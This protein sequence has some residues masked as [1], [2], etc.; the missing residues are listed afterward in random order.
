MQRSWPCVCARPV[1]WA[2]R[3]LEASE[4]RVGGRAECGVGH[5]SAAALEGDA[6]PRWCC[7]QDVPRRMQAPQ[8]FI[9]GHALQVAAAP[10]RWRDCRQTLPLL[11]ALPALPFCLPCPRDAAVLI[12]WLLSNAGVLNPRTIH[13]GTS[14]ARPWRWLVQCPRTGPPS[15]LRSALSHSLLQHRPID[16]AAP[17]QN[18]TSILE[19][20]PR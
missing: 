6:L 8:V 5:G 7:Q 9:A 3:W 14:A 1:G 10:G 4:R 17:L 11:A 13:L 20:A 16:L 12:P 15:G 2:Q 19:P 18:P